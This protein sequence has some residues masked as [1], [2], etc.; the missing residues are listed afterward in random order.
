MEVSEQRAEHAEVES[1][2][3]KDVGLA[4]LRGDAAVRRPTRGV[5]EGTNRGG[6]HCHDP[7]S[8]VSCSL[9]C[10]GCIAGDRIVLAVDPILLHDL[11]ADGLEGAES[12]MQRDFRDLDAAAADAIEDF[13]CEMKSG[14]GSCDLPQR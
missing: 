8:F 13:G 7:T 4:G 3:N 5:L 2:I 11:D 1:R 6:T 10:C 12:D 9:D 14:G